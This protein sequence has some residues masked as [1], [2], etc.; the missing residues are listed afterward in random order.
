M[1][2]ISFAPDSGVWLLSTPRTSYALRIDGTGAPCHLAW[3]PR[4]TLA[5]AG[6]LATPPVPADS[7][8]E[9][10]PPSGEELPVD[11]GTRYGPPS[12]QVRFADGTRAF[13]WEATGHRVLEAAPGESELVLEFRDRHYALAVALH[14]RVHDDCDVIERWTVL[15]NTG[16]ET[17]VLQRADSAAWTLPPRD[18]YRLSHVTGQWAAESQ[19][20]RERLAFGETVLTSRRGVTSHHA[21]PWVMLDAGDA[22]EDHGQVWSA[23]LAWSGSWRVTVQRTPDGRAGLTGGAGHEGTALPLAPGEEFTAPRFAG[24]HTDG[25]FGAASRAWH[26]HVLAHVL[27]HPEEVR[28]VLYNSWEATGFDVDE[29]GQKALAGRAAALGVELY[30][31]DD[32]WFGARRSDRAGLGDWSPSP[33]RFPDGLAPL[34]REVH[35]LGMRFGL[36]VEPEMVNPDSDLYRLHPDWVLHFPHR[37]RTELRNQ[38]VLNFARHDVA[39]WAYGWLTRLVAD[40]GI[41][42]LKWDMNRAFSEA[43]W[44]DRPDGADRLW[45]EYTRNLYAVIDRLRADH[46]GLRIETCSGGGGRVD[47][48]ILSRTDQAWASDNTDAADRVS[49]QH[50]YGQIYP[51]RTMAAWVTDVP[52]QFTAR[53]V[54]LRFRFHVAMAGVLGIGGDLGRWTDG[55]LAEGAALVAEYKRVR[56]LVQHG[57]LHRPRG[58][59]D[60]GP[61]AVQYTAPDRSEALLLVWRRAPRRGRPHLPL[62]LAGLDPDAR[63]RD[64][65]TGTVHHAKVLTGYG[66]MTELPPGDWSSTAVHLVREPEAHP[67]A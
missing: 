29:A 1:P 60:D 25:G 54:P 64:A 8:F 34:V 45:T 52:N 48:G 12:L 40:H 23:A 32:G 49:I 31:M 42:F 61:T 62:R 30:V 51:A 7:S 46:P 10:R 66:L 19:L 24:L 6:D 11:G 5:E 41:D 59:V 33:D 57:V 37:A 9:G 26:A 65:R 21:N 67:H 15:H 38:L 16:D 20:H 56:H 63:Y 2:L 4:L 55:E 35:R 22:T 43:G 17:V 39:D 36:W 58:P 13:E 50:G 28:P 47:L 44:P 3:G 18:D 53:S 27:P 14:Y